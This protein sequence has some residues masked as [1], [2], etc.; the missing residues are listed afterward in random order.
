M[1]R[2]GIILALD[3]KDGKKAEEIVQETADYID[4][5]KVGYPLVL[6]AG[7]E[8][9]SRLRRFRKPIIAD[10]KV[11]DVPHVS[12]E[13]CQLAADAGADY[14]IVQGFVGKEVIKSCSQV[15]DIF[16]VSD[17]SHPGALDF[18][19]LHGADIASISK[20]Y[21]KGIV[22]P[23]TRPQIIKTLRRIV[24]NLIIISPGVKAQG[25]KVGT[26]IA[27][28]ADF[29]IIGRAIYNSDKPGLEAKKIYNQLMKV[30]EE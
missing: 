11:A 14:V 8:V 21:A 27:A 24:G 18:I 17:M 30:D 22:A 23:A 26:A 3:V 28:G 6:S 25:A 4:A 1:R 9:I 5:V 15:A 2:S 13:I 29:E 10:L 16:V 19:T 12:M 7:I 20:K